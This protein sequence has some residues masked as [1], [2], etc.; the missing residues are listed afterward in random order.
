VLQHLRQ[1]LKLA[2]TRALIVSSPDSFKDRAEAAHLGADG[3]F[4][5]PS[6]YDGYI[7]PR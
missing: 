3:Y 2:K 5:K 4:R 1:S 6:S 7:K